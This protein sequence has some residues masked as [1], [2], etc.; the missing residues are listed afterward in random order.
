MIIRDS[1][2]PT[3]RTEIKKDQENMIAWGEGKPDPSF[4]HSGMIYI[5][6]DPSATDNLFIRKATGWFR[7]LTAPVP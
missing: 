4:G 5:D 7:V 2:L 6:L 1:A 3:T